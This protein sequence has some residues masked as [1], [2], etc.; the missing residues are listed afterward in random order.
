VAFEP[1]LV[2]RDV[3]AGG[4]E[5][6]GDLAGGHAAVEVAFLVGVGFDRDALLGDGIGD[7]PQR[8]QAGLLDFQQAG[9]VL[10]DHP[11]VVVVG[12]GRQTLRQ[13][14]IEGVAALDGD[15]IPLLAEVIDRLNQEEL[16]A[17]GFAFGEGL[18]AAFVLDAVTFGLGHGSVSGPWSVVRGGSAKRRLRVGLMS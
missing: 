11:L 17:A 15:D 6:G 5:R 9:A 3:E 18:E 13:Q 8:G 14:V 1:H 16:D 10:L 7:L 4:L 2:G 12:N